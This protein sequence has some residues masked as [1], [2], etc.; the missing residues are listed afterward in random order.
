MMK[1]RL[2]GG[3]ANPLFCAF[4]LNVMNVFYTGGF[5]LRRL[6]HPDSVWTK[7]TIRY[8]SFGGSFIS[9]TLLLSFCFTSFTSFTSFNFLGTYYRII[10]IKEDESHQLSHFFPVF[11]VLVGKHSCCSCFSGWSCFFGSG[12]HVTGNV[13]TAA[14]VAMSSRRS[15]TGGFF[16]WHQE[17]SKR[18]S[19]NTLKVFHFCYEVRAK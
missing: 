18:T 6:Q 9:V 14:F 8:S 5:T 15:M 11:F 10:V 19:S 1:M 3:G 12:R 16:L 4:I 2:V 17:C 13:S 7:T